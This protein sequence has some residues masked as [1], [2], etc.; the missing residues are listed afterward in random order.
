M[1]NDLKK[2][3]REAILNIIKNEDIGKQEQL[4][5]KLKHLGINATQATLSRD[6]R[7]MHIIRKLMKNKEH[8]YVLLTEENVGKRCNNIFK[9]S[10]ESICVQEYFIAIRTMKGMADVVGEFIDRLNDKRILGTVANNYSV[11]IVCNGEKN[12]KLVFKE[13]NDLRF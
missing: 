2:R 6:L 12:A 7:E 9:N 1:G 10:V 4:V 8:K 3:R 13:L 5:L 11:I